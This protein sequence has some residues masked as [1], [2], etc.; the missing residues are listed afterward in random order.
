ME[1]IWLNSQW[2]YSHRAFELIHR[3]HTSVGDGAE[4]D[5]FGVG[6]AASGSGSASSAIRAMSGAEVGGLVSVSQ[7]RWWSS[8]WWLGEHE[9]RWRLTDGGTCGDVRLRVVTNRGRHFRLGRGDV[10][11][12]G[13]QT[14]NVRFCEWAMQYFTYKSDQSSNGMN[15]VTY[16]CCYWEHSSNGHEWC[17]HACCY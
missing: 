6:V 16:A 9:S 2:A 11:H 1:C 5:V 13:S 4:D 10:T 12:R 7:G 15:D 17:H 14:I 8:G 3:E